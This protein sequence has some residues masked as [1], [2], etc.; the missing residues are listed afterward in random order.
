M[1]NRQTHLMD[2]VVSGG[3]DP[4]QPIPPPKFNQARRLQLNQTRLLQLIALGVFLV[5]AGT[6]YTGWTL[7]Q[8]RLDNQVLNCAYVTLGNDEDQQ[9]YDDMSKMQQRI[10]TQLDCDVPG[11]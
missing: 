5:A 7:Y 9:S 4:D 2:I 6:G 11:R 1:A 8:Q 10:V 3:S